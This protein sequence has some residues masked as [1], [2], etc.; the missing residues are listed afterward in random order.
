M[1]KN[2]SSQNLLSNGDPDDPHWMEVVT[3]SPRASQPIEE[4]TLPVA[5]PTGPQRNLCDNHI[6]VRRPPLPPTDRI[7]RIRKFL[8]PSVIATIKERVEK[9]IDLKVESQLILQAFAKKYP[10]SFKA[11]DRNMEKRLSVRWALDPYADMTCLFPQ[12]QPS[13]ETSLLVHKAESWADSATKVRKSLGISVA[14]MGLVLQR[15]LES[16]VGYLE[17][18]LTHFAQTISFAIYSDF[19]E[20]ATKAFSLNK[21]KRKAAALLAGPERNSFV[22]D[23]LTDVS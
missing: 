9:I 6:I 7:R 20:A 22:E 15:Y 19:I 4:F 14:D 18:F 3:E 23:T 5:T 17:V 2:A 16:P 11:V 10:I 8:Q 12:R 13:L 21:V 1:N